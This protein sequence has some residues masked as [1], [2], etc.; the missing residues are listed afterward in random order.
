MVDGATN[1]TLF[2]ERAVSLL[3]GLERKIWCAKICSFWLQKGQGSPLGF[4]TCSLL[5]SPQGVLYS[6]ERA[7]DLLAEL[8]LFRV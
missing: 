4:E 5:D 2:V 3:A 6:K 8:D 7:I 1:I